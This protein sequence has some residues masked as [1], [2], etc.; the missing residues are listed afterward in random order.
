MR[1]LALARGR[2]RDRGR[3]RDRDRDRGCARGRASA[4]IHGDKTKNTLFLKYNLPLLK[5][6]Y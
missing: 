6:E 2:D 3:G 4:R 1:A 5:F